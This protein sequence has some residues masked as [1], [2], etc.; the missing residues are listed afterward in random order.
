M[1]EFDAL[2]AAFCN[3]P[4]PT[5]ICPFCLHC[6][7]QAPEAYRKK[8]WEDGPA[9]LKEE[10]WLLENRASLRLGEL[11]VKAGK[12]TRGQLSEVIE[13]QRLTRKKFGEVLVM[14][15]FLSPEEV[16]LYLMD[17]KGID[18]IDLKETKVDFLLMDQVGRELCLK[19][20]MV[21]FETI[22]IRGFDVLRLAVSTHHRLT[23]I[24]EEESLRRYTVI[25][26]LS[27][28]GDIEDIL[29]RLQE[30]EN[31]KSILVLEDGP[32]EG[33]D[34]GGS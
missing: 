32:E 17:Q 3:H 18:E 11:L 29:S 28:P 4:N 27:R 14:M 16:S 33:G 8:F 23:E 7:C 9:K 21:P 24:K 26:Y 1:A 30:R 15:D 34:R 12:L 19:Y 10:K 5:K 6:A 13:K 31:G 2:E 25:P 22:R 20:K